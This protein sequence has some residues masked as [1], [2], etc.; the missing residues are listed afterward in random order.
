MHSA[1]Q[2]KQLH[3]TDRVCWIAISP[4]SPPAH[5]TCFSGG[6]GMF[7]IR[8][9]PQ[10]I[11]EEVLRL[12]FPPADILEQWHRG[13]D[14]LWPP[15]RL[16]F[17][18]GTDVLCRVGPTDWAAG[19]ITQQWYRESGP[20][21]PEGHYAPYKIR[22]EDGRDIFAPQDLDQIIRLNPSGNRNGVPGRQQEQQQEVPPAVVEQQQD[23]NGGSASAEASRA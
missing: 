21:W 2:V 7:D 20:A 4:S 3:R 22:L 16:R 14:G 18:V 6:Q 23:N 11:T 1:L 9:E 15:K 17:E 13:K 19:T 12:V 10:K 5:L 8:M